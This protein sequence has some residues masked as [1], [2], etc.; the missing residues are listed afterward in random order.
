MNKIM[1]QSSGNG[2]RKWIGLFLG[3]VLALSIHLFPLPDSIVNVVGSVEGARAAWVT[4]SL[5][6]LMAVWWVSEAIPIPVTS[7]LP[8]VILP[9]FDVQSIKLTAA[10]Y[11]NP[12]VVL[13]MGGFIIA[14]AIER[15]DLHSR[16]ALSVV[17]KVG[18]NPSM[19]IG[20]FMLAAALLSM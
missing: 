3:P 4:L 2:Y 16:I 12:V 9:F 11:M 5:L 1:I 18:A 8:M 15:W 6:I 13:L 17:A 20:G 14:K 19:L 7:L 10:E